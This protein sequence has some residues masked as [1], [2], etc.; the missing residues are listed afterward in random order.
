MKLA[1]FK[2]KVPYPLRPVIL[3]LLVKKDGVLLAM[4][5]RGFGKGWWNGVGGKV[6]GEE[7]IE[8][9]AKREAFEEIG[10]KPTVLEKVATINFYFLDESID[11]DW[12]QQM[13]VFLCDKWAG[14]PAESE[15]MRPKWHKRNDLPV[16]KMWAGDRIWMPLIL[17]G[18]NIIAD[19]AF[20]RNNE[21][22][23]Y[24]ID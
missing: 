8:Q 10:V 4:K 7:T 15:E 13:H 24:K 22:V 3:V 21:V 9:A 14:K 20:N 12:N 2:S 16:D 19:F 17:S 5:K 23:E 18:E 1:E 6:E 11:K